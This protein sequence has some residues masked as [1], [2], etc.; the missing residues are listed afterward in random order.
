MFNRCD[1]YRR[2]KLLSEDGRTTPKQEAFLAKHEQSCEMCTAEHALTLQALEFLK[3]SAIEPEPDPTF[4]SRFIRR[5]RVERRARTVSYWLPAVV[6]AVVA[7]VAL[8]A[9]L[10]I[11]FAAPVRE[12]VDLKGRE[13]QLTIPSN[14]GE[15]VAPPGQ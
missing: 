4:E 9:V 12:K 7:S 1:R 13:A 3:T 6:G 10:Q 8:L 11:L 15:T 5:W 2:L 14:F